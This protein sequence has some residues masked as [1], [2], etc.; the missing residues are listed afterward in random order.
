MKKKFVLFMLICCSFVS[1]TACQSAELEGNCFPMVVTVGYD[2][3][4]ITYRAG[5]PRAS[6]DGTEGTKSNEI[7]VP[8][9]KEKTFEKSKTEYEKRLNKKADYNHLKVLVLEDDLLENGAGYNEM[10]DYLAET[11]EFPRNTYVCVVDDIEDL[12]EID[13]NLPQDLGTYLEEYLK[14]HE[15][16]KDK[17]FS[18]G[19]L[20]DE[21][22]NQVM[23][24]YLPYLEVEDNYV[25]WKGY[26][27]NSGK[28]WQES[29]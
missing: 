29:Y 23:V 27:N 12:F 2:D 11:E 4:K 16:K 1:L 22:E 28:I 7:Q 6:S 3:R 5:F 25:E 26:M 9:V 15:A 14:N 18:L 10:L 21:K 20:I 19:D 17:I 24:L 8:M 13:K